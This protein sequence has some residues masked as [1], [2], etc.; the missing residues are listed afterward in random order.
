MLGEIFR[1]LTDEGVPVDLLM[2][3]QG[4]QVPASVR[5]HLTLSWR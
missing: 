1:M 3:I 5:R 4:D 2:R